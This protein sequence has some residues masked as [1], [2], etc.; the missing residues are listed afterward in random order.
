M[1][2]DDVVLAID[3]GT[4]SVRALLFDLRGNLVAKSRVLIE[5]YFS[6]QPGW[7]EQHPD[8]FWESVCQACRRLWDETDI[9]KDAV[10]G[11]AVTTQRATMVNVDQEGKPL[12]PAIVWLDQRRT[13]GLD[14]VGGWWGAAFRVAREMGTVAYLQAEAEANWIYTHQPDIWQQTHKY[15]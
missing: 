13:E 7:A 15:L 8:Y 10:K 3:N 6:K 1:V 5:P 12:R 4:Q 2:T 9:P 14:P 11:V